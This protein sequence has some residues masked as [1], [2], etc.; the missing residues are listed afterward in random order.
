MSAERNPIVQ[1]AL[2]TLC[3]LC[4]EACPC[5]AVTLTPEGLRFACGAHCAALRERGLACPGAGLCEEV[6]PVGALRCPVEIA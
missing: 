1:D 2:C 3:G 5:G 4:V 6:C